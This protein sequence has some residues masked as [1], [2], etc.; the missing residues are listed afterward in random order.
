MKSCAA[1]FLNKYPPASLNENSFLREYALDL[2]VL[3]DADFLQHFHC[4]QFTCSLTF[5]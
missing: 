4:I 2:F 5:R 1:F 3:Y